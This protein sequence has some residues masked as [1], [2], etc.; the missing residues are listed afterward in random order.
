M[1]S[2]RRD[3]E[4]TAVT[5]LVVLVFLASHEGWGVPLVGDSHRWAAGVI[6]ALGMATCAVG[7]SS[8]RGLERAPTALFGVLGTAALVFGVLALVT[9][10]LT[11][12]SFLV[13]ADVL[14]W[15]AAT[16]RHLLRTP[17]R[18]LHT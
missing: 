8:A 12:L 1:T 15:A 11:A 7:S 5:A 10:S 17:H 18:P 14:L 6:L 2:I 3:L 13:L 4:A 9:G 16:A